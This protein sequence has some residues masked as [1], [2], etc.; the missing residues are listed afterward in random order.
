MNDER[1]IAWLETP[2]RAP[3]L[4]REGTEIGTTEAVLG[5]DEDDIFHGLAVNLKGITAG[6]V[7]V[8]ADKVDRITTERVY[9]QLAPDEAGDLPEYEESRWFDFRGVGRLLRKPKWKQ[10]E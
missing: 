1:T 4:D 6:V 3:V 2:A 9:T 7:E 10:D 8:P 5:D